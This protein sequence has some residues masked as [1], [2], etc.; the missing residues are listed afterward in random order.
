MAGLKTATLVAS[1]ALPV[2]CALSGAAGAQQRVDLAEAA[3]RIIRQLPPIDFSSYGITPPGR[4][5]RRLNPVAEALGMAVERG[6]GLGVI[7]KIIN[8]RTGLATLHV[9]QRVFGIPVWGSDITLT[10]RQKQSPQRVYGIALRGMAQ[11]LKHQRPRFG[12]ERARQIAKR[13]T[14]LKEDDSPAPAFLT[15]KGDQK[16]RLVIHAP[17]DGAPR[18]AWEV[19]LEG[20]IDGRMARP[21]VLVD[22]MNGKVLLQ[23]NDLHDLRAPGVGGNEKTGCYKYGAGSMPPLPARRVKGGMCA[24][25]NKVATVWD[26]QEQKNLNRCILYRFDC[27]R[28]IEKRRVNGGCSPVND[29]YFF[30][31][32]TYRLYKEW[33]GTPPIRNKMN[34]L[35]HYDKGLENAFWN[36]R[37]QAMFFGDGRKTFY[38]LVALDVTAHEISHGYTAQH[39]GL[40]YRE[41]SGSINEAFSD[42]AGETAEY[43][44]RL[45]VMKRAGPVVAGRPRPQGP[46][47]GP[48]PKPRPEPKPPVRRADNDANSILRGSPP[49]Y[50]GGG[51]AASVNALLSG[52]GG[53]GNPYGG[54]VNGGHGPGGQMDAGPAHGLARTRPVARPN[55]GGQAA[56]SDVFGRPVPDFRI[57]A[58]IT[59]NME[60][61]RFF[62]H[63][64]KDGMSIGHVR[65]YAALVR[66]CARLTGG[67]ETRKQGCIVH[68]ASGIFNRAF[69]LL[70]TSDGWDLRKA[71]G[72]FL[73]ANGQYW[74]KSETFKSAARKVIDAAG[75]LK[76]DKAAVRAA[77]VKVGVLH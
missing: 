60:A 68:T 57:G 19:V 70:A 56:K 29:A 5:E 1:A 49:A 20:F 41:H 26:C 65:E 48:E 12:A 62:A 6:E 47:A 7:R 67:N 14:G 38:P 24:L 18:L 36:D 40:I 59:R 63:P 64:E 72:V 45:K 32:I 69:Y 33:Y 51:S 73:L 23:Y 66:K 16:P 42:M 55:A 30:G 9:D 50:G 61:L 77:F 13:A 27:S 11:A 34:L 25:S 46:G 53:G 8:G 58:D 10:G 71:F 35:V 22:A 2:V 17:R 15:G 31:L 37:Y 4:V 52:G 54:D 39:S 28:S 76:L 74:G 21:H 43:Y 75:D 44:Y 3:T